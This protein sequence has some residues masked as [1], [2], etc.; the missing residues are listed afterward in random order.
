M[1]NNIVEAKYIHA[2]E[3]LDKKKEDAL[4]SLKGLQDT[5]LQIHGVEDALTSQKIED[6][7]EQYNA[8]KSTL[9]QHILRYEKMQSQSDADIRINNL[10][11][12]NQI[13]YEK[14]D[15]SVLADIRNRKMD[16]NKWYQTIFQAEEKNVEAENVYP[17]NASIQETGKI[18][19]DLE[20]QK[21]YTSLMIQETHG[22]G[23]VSGECAKML[24][25]SGL[26]SA[27]SIE[28]IHA[29]YQQPT[30]LSE[31]PLGQGNRAKFFTPALIRQIGND[32]LE[33]ASRDPLTFRRLLQEIEEMNDFR[34]NLNNEGYS[35]TFEDA[36]FLNQS[37]V[38]VEYFFGLVANM[39]TEDL[40]RRGYKEVRFVYTKKIID[41][42]RE[43]RKTG[44]DL[45][46]HLN[47]Y[48]GAVENLV[49][50]LEEGE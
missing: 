17:E 40:M 15:E 48:S 47:I 35:I 6:V 43:S 30:N 37:G 21:K 2:I 7:R 41:A 24:L 22:F 14:L 27:M 4:H 25:D 3:A 31:V 44:H 38:G 49:N 39:Q 45:E 50:Q 20:L 1:E 26:P 36:F 46:S 33:K 11:E 34:D 32:Y 28:I 23:L 9:E 29:I 8:K 16:S 42:A 5:Y 19:E 18:S 10:S 12:S 13:P